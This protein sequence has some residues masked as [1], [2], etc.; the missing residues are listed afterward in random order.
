MRYEIKK[1]Y[2]TNFGSFTNLTALEI[3]RLNNHEFAQ[4]DLYGIFFL[5]RSSI[6]NKTVKEIPREVFHKRLENVLASSIN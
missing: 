5:K 3:E 2:Q 4:N 1:Y 6:A